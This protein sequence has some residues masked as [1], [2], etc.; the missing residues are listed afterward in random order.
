MEH[1]VH[2]LNSRLKRGIDGTLKKNCPRRLTL[3]ER[4]ADGAAETGA[5]SI[6]LLGHGD[7][8]GGVCLYGRSRMVTQ[9]HTAR[10]Y[11]IIGRFII[12]SFKHQQKLKMI[13]KP[14]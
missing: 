1:I 9:D 11:C 13:M 8:V 5:S 7:D 3:A 4:T 10:I 2:V 14:I 12:Y 6:A